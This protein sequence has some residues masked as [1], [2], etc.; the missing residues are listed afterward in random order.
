MHHLDANIILTDTKHGFRPKDSCE[1][2]FI[3]TYH[4]ITRQLN[5]RDIKKVDRILFEFSKAFDKV[6][7]LRYYGISGP[8]LHWI[9]AFLTNRT[10]PVFLDGSSS[11]AVFVSS[12]VPQGIA[13]N[14]L[15]SYFNY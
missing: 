15:F 4:D 13:L 5:R 12:G 7:Q 8:I 2:Q 1:S 10:Q 3:T 14:P 11:D 6:P 9:T